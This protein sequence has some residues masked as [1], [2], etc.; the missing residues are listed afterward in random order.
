MNHINGV[1]LNNVHV[2]YG[3]VQALDGATVTFTPGQVTALIGVNGSGKSTLF[4]SIIGDVQPQEGSVRIAG[5]APTQAR[6]AGLVSYVPQTEAV[7][8]DFPVSVRDVVMMGRYHLLGLTRRPRRVDHDAVADALDRVELSTLAD[9]QIGELSGGQRKRAFIA[10][11]IAQQAQVVLLDEPFAGVDKPS[12]ATIVALLRQL[13][14]QGATV[15]VSTHDLSSLTD[16]ADHAV[17]LLRS[18]KYAGP[19]ELALTPEKLS[20]AFGLATGTSGAPT[21]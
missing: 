11:A 1:T 21:A 18:V 13:A 19:V 15:V 5:R 7:D 6:A 10:R 20:L 2:R 12:E 4:K 14:T 8:W 9:R 17:L 16:L 3:S